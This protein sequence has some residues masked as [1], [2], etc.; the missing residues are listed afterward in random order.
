[1]SACALWP[2]TTQWN[3]SCV[4]R[5]SFAVC[6]H[7]GQVRAELRG[8]RRSLP[9]WRFQLLRAHGPRD[10]RWTLWIELWRARRRTSRC[11]RP[12]PRSIAAGRRPRIAP[13]QGRAAGPLRCGPGCDGARLRTPGRARRVEYARRP[14]PAWGGPRQ[15]AAH[16]TVGDRAADGARVSRPLRNRSGGPRPRTPPTGR[17]L[18][19][20]RRS[21]PARPAHSSRPQARWPCLE[22]R[23]AGQPSEQRWSMPG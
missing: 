1:M 4:G 16:G 8:P 20:T 5:F 12:G 11:A 21:L 3:F 22:I 18:D 9:A 13:R 2:H 10:P 6:P 14:R 19:A 7:S 15:S 23:A 17:G